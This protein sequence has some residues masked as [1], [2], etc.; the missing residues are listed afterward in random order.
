MGALEALAVSHLCYYYCFSEVLPSPRCIW[1]FFELCFNP[2][3]AI[4]VCPVMSLL[5][6]PAY[7]IM[8]SRRQTIDPSFCLSLTSLFFPLLQLSSHTLADTAEMLRFWALA[9][10]NILLLS[11]PLP[12]T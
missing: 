5:R 6:C 8:E 1:Q 9:C 12:F 10:L 11:F 3:A 4:P 2:S 7:L